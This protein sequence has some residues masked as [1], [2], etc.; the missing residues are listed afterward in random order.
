MKMKPLLNPDH[1]PRGDMFD[2]LNW[3]ETLCRIKGV[4]EITDEDVLDHLIQKEGRI[5]LAK[6]FVTDYFLPAVSE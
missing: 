3:F 5:D 1:P 4:T 6:A 2:A